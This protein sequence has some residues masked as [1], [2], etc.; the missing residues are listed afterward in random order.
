MMK[1]QLYLILC[2]AVVAL[3]VVYG[4]ERSKPPGGIL[5]TAKARDADP[6]RRSGTTQEPAPKPIFLPPGAGRIITGFADGGQFTFKLGGG[7]SGSTF[8]FAEGKT[9][10]NG[11]PPEHI[12]FDTDEAFYV[13]SGTFRVK[14]GDQVKD[15]GPGSFVFAPRGIPH[16][17][18]NT[19]KTEGRLLTVASPTRFEA[20]TREITDALRRMPPGHPDQKILDAIMD[21]CKMRIVGPPLGG[22]IQLE[23]PRKP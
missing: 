11:G 4:T 15:V 3:L 1:R 13:L 23:P 7:E 14:V 2:T 20:C 10:P 6:S 21:K 22:G 18:V 9:P 12:H 17:F 19:G 5:G 8:E 16:A